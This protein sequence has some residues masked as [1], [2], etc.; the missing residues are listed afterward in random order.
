MLSKSCNL[1]GLIAAN[2]QS[3]PSSSGYLQLSR[4]PETESDVSDD[5]I[6]R[7][8]E[9]DKDYFNPSLY[10]RFKDKIPANSLTIGLMAICFASALYFNSLPSEDQAKVAGFEEGSSESMS[11]V[12]N[13]LTYVET[14]SGQKITEL[15][16][17]YVNTK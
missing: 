15:F 12:R 4:N 1:T 13:A 6:E 5:E 14:Y 16:T 3:N 8:E 7:A 11:A 2:S 10:S 17:Q 9:A